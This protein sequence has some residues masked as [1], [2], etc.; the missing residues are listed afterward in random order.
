MQAI[1]WIT[2]G[3]VAVLLGA[4]PALAQDPIIYPTKGQS[5]DQQQ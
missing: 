4:A 1:N 5:Q 3:F 2:L